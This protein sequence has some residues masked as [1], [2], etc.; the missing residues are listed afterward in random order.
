MTQLTVKGGWLDGAAIRKARK[1]YRCQYYR[2]SAAGGFCRKPIPPGA[3]YVEGEMTD[4]QQTRNGAFI[5][6]KY[7]P[8]CA[9]PEA[10]ATI[11]DQGGGA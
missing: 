4:C 1:P 5:R 10:L 9:G 3:Y 6:D 8:E 2:G 7:C 11:A